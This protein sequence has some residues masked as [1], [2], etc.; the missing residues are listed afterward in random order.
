MV[1]EGLRIPISRRSS[2]STL[3]DRG[4]DSY[5]QNL[6]GSGG[7]AAGLYFS[8]EETSLRSLEVFRMMEEG[9]CVIDKFCFH[10]VITLQVIRD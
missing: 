6:A 1:E 10:R 4:D 2:W 5:K 8:G 9:S 3:S 7:S